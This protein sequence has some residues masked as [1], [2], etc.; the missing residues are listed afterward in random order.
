[1]MK[2]KINIWLG[3][4]VIGAF[5]I[6]SLAQ[7]PPRT[8]AANSVYVVK[9]KPYSADSISETVQTL[10]DGNK[11]TR[12]SKNKVHRDS[13]GRTRREDLPSGLVSANYLS[14]RETITITDPIA[15]FNYYLNPSA[16]T[17]RRQ[18]ITI[19]GTLGEKTNN[20][21][22]F[23]TTDANAAV[24]KIEGIEC[25]IKSLKTTIAPGAIG[26]EREIITTSE[27][28]Y[29]DDLH[30]ILL[31]KRNDPQIGIN[32]TKL[33]NITRTEPDKSLFTIPSDYKI[34]N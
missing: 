14:L 9:N 12:I 13:E 7:D 21:S 34:V 18:P 19:K 28:C 10:V 32:T 24:E 11:I 17:A 8:M 3:V 25:T 22:G 6:I 27:T 4:F 30:I 29:S 33:A 20:T 23:T 2:K 1:M 26:N 15:G 16:K 5:S 31:S